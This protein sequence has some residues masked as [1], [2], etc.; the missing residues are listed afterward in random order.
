VLTL[1][2]CCGGKR[3]DSIGT[4][5]ETDLENEFNIFTSPDSEGFRI[6]PGFWEFGSLDSEGGTCTVVFG[7]LY[8]CSVLCFLMCLFVCL[9]VWL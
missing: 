4:E 8:C 2:V 6:R 1:F 3:E 7:C 9:F 5:E